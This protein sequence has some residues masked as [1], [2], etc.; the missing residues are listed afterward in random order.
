M[1]NA[2][3]G[4]A[5]QSGIQNHSLGPDGNVRTVIVGNDG[6]RDATAFGVCLTSYDRDV[7][8]G[9]VDLMNRAER[10][11]DAYFAGRADYEGGSAWVDSSFNPDDGYCVS[12]HGWESK[13]VPAGRNYNDVYADIVDKLVWIRDNGWTDSNGPKV[14]IGWWHY[15]GYVYFDISVHYDNINEA[16]DAAYCEGQI[17]FYDIAESKERAVSVG[18]ADW[19]G[20]AD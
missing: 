1:S 15:D 6:R 13:F 8:A 17:A 9:N 20:L 5:G 16:A 12:I 19:W 3:N 14:C 10:I 7:H 2:H 11:A 18:R 4:H